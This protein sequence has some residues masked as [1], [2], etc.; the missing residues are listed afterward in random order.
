ML[1]AD[2]GYGTVLANALR[3]HPQSLGLAYGA[4]ECI[5]GLSEC[6]V[7]A[8]NQKWEDIQIDGYKD[9]EEAAPAH[10]HMT[11]GEVKRAQKRK[12]NECRRMRD[13]YFKCVVEYSYDVV[14]VVSP[15]ESLSGGEE[16]SNSEGKNNR[17][18]EKN[19]A[20]SEGKTVIEETKSK[21]ESELG[22]QEMPSSLM[23]I[24]PPS[25]RVQDGLVEIFISSMKLFS[26]E[27]P[28]LMESG[29]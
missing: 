29:S 8:A 25:V 26:R 20:V 4:A 24:L 19:Q 12:R 15:S 17:R 7:E 6:V 3:V 16:K 10:Q 28:L 22:E 13:E 14:V 2:Q 23:T 5:V 9:E 21:I 1:L 11:L 18:E 27:S